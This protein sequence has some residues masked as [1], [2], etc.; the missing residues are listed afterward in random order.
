MQFARK[1]EIQTDDLFS[2]EEL[3]EILSWDIADEIK[4][5]LLKFTNEGISIIGK[6]YTPAVCMYILDNN[7]MEENLIELFSFF[8][9]WND[10]VQNIIFALSIKYITDIIDSPKDISEN[11]KQKLIH[12]DNLSKDTKLNGLL[13]CCLP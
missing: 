7:F 13:Q 11:L 4:I 10:S 3:M 9:E 5:G 6:N 12:S 1:S 8:D 2:V